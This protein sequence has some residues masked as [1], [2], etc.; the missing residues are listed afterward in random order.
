M[1]VRVQGILKKNHSYSFAVSDCEI[2]LHEIQQHKHPAVTH[3]FHFPVYF[4]HSDSEK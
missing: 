1:R 3:R 4:P 2:L